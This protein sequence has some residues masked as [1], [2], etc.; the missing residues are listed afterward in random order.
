MK[1]LKLLVVIAVLITLLSGCT[2]AVR[3]GRYGGGLYRTYPTYPPY[4]WGGGW[5]YR[6]HCDWR[7]CW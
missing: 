7:G 4:P 5:R 1:I 2:V 3:P 6:R